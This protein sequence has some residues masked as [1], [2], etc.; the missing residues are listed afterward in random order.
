MLFQYLHEIISYINNS[1]VTFTSTKENVF[2]C[3][4]FKTCRR[5]HISIVRIVGLAIM[6]L[7]IVGHLCSCFVLLCISALKKHPNPLFMVA[8]K[9]SDLFYINIGLFSTVTLALSGT[10]PL[11]RS[12]FFCKTKNL[13]F[14]VGYV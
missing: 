13:F 3:R 14:L 11:S 4:Y 5:C 6:I 7:G 12:L 2:D 10:N 1:M 8:S 9:V